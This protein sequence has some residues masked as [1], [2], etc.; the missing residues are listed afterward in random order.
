MAWEWVGFG[1]EY[2]DKEKQTAQKQTK[3]RVWLHP[4]RLDTLF[5]RLADIPPSPTI[6]WRTM[7]VCLLIPEHPV[8]YFNITA[9]STRT[10]GVLGLFQ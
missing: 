2:I 10:Q 5:T 1:A 3:N 7:Q 9:V 8:C 6:H 4:R